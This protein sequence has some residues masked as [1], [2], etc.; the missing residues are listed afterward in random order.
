MKNISYLLLDDQIEDFVTG[1]RQDR[2]YIGF[3]NT[4]EQA[5]IN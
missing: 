3:I 4:I 2:I 1:K 5:N